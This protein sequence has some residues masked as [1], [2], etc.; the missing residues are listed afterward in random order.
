MALVVE[1]KGS[2]SDYTRLTADSQAI[3]L[4]DNRSKHS[5]HH[6]LNGNIP[7]LRRSG[8]AHFAIEVPTTKGAFIPLDYS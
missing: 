8:I 5:I 3:F 6:Y 2:P 1:Q 7:A 4:N